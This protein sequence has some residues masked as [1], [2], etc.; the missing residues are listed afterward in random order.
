MTTVASSG[1]RVGLPDLTCHPGK[2]QGSWPHACD[3]SV[4]DPFSS[5]H[6]TASIIVFLFFSEACVVAFKTGSNWST[7]GCMGAGVCLW[8]KLHTLVGPLGLVHINTAKS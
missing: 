6:M 1:F 7:L 4:L 3:V 8:Y 2:Y 5:M